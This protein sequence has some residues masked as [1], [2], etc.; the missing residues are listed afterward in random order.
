[1]RFNVS[2]PCEGRRLPWLLR[3]EVH[4]VPGKGQSVSPQPPAPTH[5]STQGEQIFLVLRG[6]KTK[7][8]AGPLGRWLPARP[9]ACPASCP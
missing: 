7:A 6:H 2:T 3:S 8:A 9:A 5:T 1:M 4:A